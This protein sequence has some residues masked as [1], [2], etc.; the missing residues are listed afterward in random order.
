MN[1]IR[2]TTYLRYVERR[3]DQGNMSVQVVEGSDHG[4]YPPV[5]LY[6]IVYGPYVWPS[7]Y[8]KHRC[9]CY[10]IHANAMWMRLHCPMHIESRP[11]LCPSHTRA[12][13]YASLASIHYA[14]ATWQ[15]FITYYLLRSEHKIHIIYWIGFEQPLA[16]QHLLCGAANR[17]HRMYRNLSSCIPSQVFRWLRHRHQY[18]I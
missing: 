16:D 13:R 12:R 18:C 5:V 1:W 6:Y 7:I 15:I 2:L 3:C 11:C 9:V 10:F 4:T 17:L 14:H 8:N